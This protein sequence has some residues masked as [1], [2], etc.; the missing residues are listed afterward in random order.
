MA[1][2]YNREELWERFGARHLQ[3]A[4]LVRDHLKEDPLHSPLMEVKLHLLP[5]GQ[6]SVTADTE[7]LHEYT[8]RRIIEALPGI[9]E[10]FLEATFTDVDEAHAA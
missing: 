2:V 8:T 7:A 1:E 9:V 4:H 5:D 3:F 6:L 10:A